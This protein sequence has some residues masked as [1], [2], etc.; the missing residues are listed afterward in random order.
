MDIFSRWSR[1]S[2]LT[3]DVVERFDDGMAATTGTLRR[4]LADY[5]VSIGLNLGM[6]RA[7]LRR[8]A[9]DR[10]E[11]ISLLHHQ[12]NSIVAAAQSQPLTCVFD[13]FGGIFGVDGVAGLM[14]TKF[15]HHYRDLGL[16]FAGSQ[17]TLLVK[18][19][20]DQAMPF[21][22]QSDLITIQPF[23]PPAA[24]SIVREGFASTDRDA[25]T[26]AE[27]IARVGGG[28]PY[29]TMQLADEAWST[30]EPGGEF[31]DHDWPSVLQHLLDR[32]NYPLEVIFSARTPTEQMVLRLLANGEALFGVGAERLGLG[33]SGAYRARDHL[34]AR[35]DLTADDSRFR[36][37]DPIFAEW[38]RVRFP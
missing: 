15:Q 32:L 22:A 33:S 27:H 12:L 25:G 36:I 1:H 14:R 7:E 2:P 24:M 3:G 37:V 29:R 10:P 4:W 30:V 9:S 11:P 6:I 13:E 20:T 31:A 21:Y 8:R 5:Y 35:G 19:F 38:L 18:M 16:L 28:H 34:L 23:D 26:A 17:P